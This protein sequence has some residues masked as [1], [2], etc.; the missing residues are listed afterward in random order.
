MIEERYPQ[1]AWTQ[2]YTD[3]SATNAINNGGAGV[4][5]RSPDGITRSEA[6]PTG[7]NCTNYRAEVEALVHATR[8][9]SDA[10]DEQGQVVFLTDARSVLEA[11]TAGKL[12]H[13]Q[14][15]LNNLTCLRIVLQWIPSHC[16][17]AG[18]EEA[19]KLAKQGSEM[20]QEE[21][22]TTYDE[23]RT[24]VKSLFKVP[25][26]NDSYHQLSRQDQVII[27][28]LRTG[29]NKLNSHL[30]RLKIV[31][32][33]RCQCKEGDQTAKHILQEC[34]DLQP[35]RR[36]IWPLATS[37]EDKLYGPVEM[38]LKTA[39]FITESGVRV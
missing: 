19:D 18:N 37:L 17:V 4:F 14:K 35:L 10:I 27:F 26:P 21:N 31:G 28:R 5:V 24:V 15:A 9:L 25:Q 3:G 29:H 23:M 38:L 6:I 13:L 16:V 2:V 33:P 22:S 30:H 12:P 34:R 8:I 11:T 36:E 20:E 7:M 32:S 1:E 39:S